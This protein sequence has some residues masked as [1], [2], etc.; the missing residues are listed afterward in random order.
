MKTL[1]TFMMALLC[2]VSL[3][4]SIWVGQVLSFDQRL[5]N[6][7]ESVSPLRSNS[8]NCIGMAQSSDSFTPDTNANYV[9]L[10]FKG[11]M[12]VMMESAVKNV[13]GMDLKV[14]ETTFGTQT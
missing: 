7:G 6:N 14:H 9:S 3:S 13:E 12:V 4:Q 2:Q 10:G 8:L 11:E 5:N 1:L